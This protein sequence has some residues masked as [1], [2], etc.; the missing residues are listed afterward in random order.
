MIL[1]NGLPRL[2][3]ASGAIANR[4]VI[5]TMERSW[6]GR[7]NAGLTPA[8]LAELPGI[9][10]W[11]LAGLERL[12]QGGY[13]AEL[14]SSAE[15]ALTLADLVSPVAAFIR[16]ECE[17]GPVCEVPAKA[18]FEAWRAWC[19]DN[20]H[21]AGSAQSFGRDLRAVLPALRMTKP[22][23]EDGRQERAYAGLRLSTAHIAQSRAS[24]RLSGELNG[25]RRNEARLSPL[26]DQQAA[27]R[28]H[29]LDCPGD[30]EFYGSGGHPC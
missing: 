2:G 24:A 30:H 19:N 17:T 5:L 3:D 25:L 18:I 10:N 22:R 23:G 13:L 8:L 9:L 4:F 29:R 12:T 1:S 26:S 20:G 21:R 27:G 11:S 28:S 16:S 15:A 7:E 14:P 6:L